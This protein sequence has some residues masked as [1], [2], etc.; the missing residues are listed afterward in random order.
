VFDGGQLGLVSILL[1]QPNLSGS[2][3]IRT[4]LNVAEQAQ[5]L[6]LLH[7]VQP[8]LEILLP[9]HLPVQFEEG[10]VMQDEAILALFKLFRKAHIDDLVC[11]GGGE[12]T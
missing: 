3:L 1:P 4:A 12:F 6:L 9:R 11:A 10:V 7:V 5:H 8:Q 2:L